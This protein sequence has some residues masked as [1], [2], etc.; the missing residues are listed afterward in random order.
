MTSNQSVSSS[1]SSS[2]SA[3]LKLTTGE[4]LQNPKQTADY[5][6]AVIAEEHQGRAIPASSLRLM[7]QCPEALGRS[8]GNLLRQR[9]N[10]TSEDLV[11]KIPRLKIIMV[12]LKDTYLVIRLEPPVDI[13]RGDKIVAHCDRAFSQFY[14]SI[15]AVI[16]LPKPPAIIRR[17]KPD[18]SAS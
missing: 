2:S 14:R 18:I 13:A 8:I 1:L 10:I 6:V 17:R 7:A 9:F 12:E 11:Q 16:S 4:E 15:R 3:H 5:Y